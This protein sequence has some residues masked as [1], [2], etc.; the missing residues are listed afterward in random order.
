MSDDLISLSQAAEKLR[1]SYATVR[2]LVAAGHF[3]IVKLTNKTVRIDPQ[4]IDAYIAART[5]HAAPPSAMTAMPRQR[6]RAL[7]A[8][9]S[10]RAP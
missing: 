6:V 5:V 7:R 4:V 10:A 8:R 2:R 9:A 3:P 1:V